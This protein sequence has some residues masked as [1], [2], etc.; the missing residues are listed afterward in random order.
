[1]LLDV[2]EQYD[3]EKIA[4]F[5]SVWER[6]LLHLAQ[7]QDHKKI[8]SFLCKVGILDLDEQDKMVVFG[9][10]NE[11]VLTQAKKFFA[12]SLKE[13]INE[14][15]NPHFSIKF[16]IYAKFSNTNALLV[17]LKKLLHIKE[18]KASELSVEKNHLK[19]ELSD[20][21][22]ILFDP[23]FTFDTFV[24]GA[25]NNIAFSAA[26][27]VTANP[28]KAYNPLFLY[29]TVGL[30]KTH[31][32]QAIGNDIMAKY[33][34]KVV[35]YLPTSKLIDEIVTAI[36]ANKLPNVLKKFDDV[37]VLLIDDVQFLADKDKTQEIFHN[38]FN[39][40]QLKQKQIILSSDRP[41]KELIHIEPRLKS[42]FALG[43]VA[44]IKSPD[45]ET[46]IAILQ[47]KLMN[48]GEDLDFNLLEILA[49]YIK[50]NVRELEGA[51]NIL[52]SRKAILS[53]EV[54]QKDVY[55][56]LKTLGY[57]IEQTNDATQTAV[58][59]NTKGTKNFDLLVDMVAQYYGL[60]VQELKSE[61]RKKEIT[62]ARQL[63]MLLSKKYFQWTLER[64]GD[65]FGGKGHAAVI[66][67][68]NNTEKKLKKDHDIAHDYEVFVDWL[69]K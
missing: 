4:L 15:Y 57:K 56:C 63:L 32:M 48:K 29:G 59:S 55:E 41:P 58:Q 26:K 25:T 34:E 47:S 17:D 60:S 35:V 45:F 44:D 68:I 54:D 62:N 42:R 22:G 10:P 27:A 1:M 18:T 64:I 8:L 36:K 16:V 21:F 39:D 52:L 69:G 49:K 9:V 24:V 51:L 7:Q 61:S 23:K 13:S 20:F 19:N 30:G 53:K 50:E 38:I 2:V 6:T 14:V 65:Y 66:Y 46:R 3:A 67:A 12:K 40:F 33:P 28:G 37:D 31:L 11:F 5:R 43:L